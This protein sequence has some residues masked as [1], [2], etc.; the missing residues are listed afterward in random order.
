MGFN[1]ILWDLPSGKRLHRYGSYRTSACLK[2]Q[3]TVSMAIFNSSVTLPDGTVV[4]RTRMIWVCTCQSCIVYACQR[5]R[6]CIPLLFNI[7]F[8]QDRS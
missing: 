8:I 3:S 5:L 6:V 4:N 1:W 7:E 2:I